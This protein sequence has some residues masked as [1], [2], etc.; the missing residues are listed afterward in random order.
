MCQRRCLY[1]LLGL[2][3]SAA[4]IFYNDVRAVMGHAGGIR[5]VY[6]LESE[7]VGGGKA[8]EL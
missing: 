7:Q 3:S 5:D 8:R 1:G 4:G 6:E 2:C